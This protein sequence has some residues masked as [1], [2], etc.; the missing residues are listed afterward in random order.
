MD[1]LVYKFNKFKIPLF[2]AVI[3][4]GE[5]LFV[6]NQISKAAEQETSSHYEHEN[7]LAT[8]NVKT[9]ATNQTVI[10]QTSSSGGIGQS[11]PI[12]SDVKV[13][14]GKNMCRT[15]NDHPHK[16]KKKIPVHIDGECC[17]D[18]DEIPNSNCYYPQPRYAKMIQ[19]YLN[20]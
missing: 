20:R 19:K 18:P 8:E 11:G 3:F 17:L 13:V 9:T 14:N 6:P 5:F 4:L 10:R 12:L 16:S 7:F 15:N 1:S 2:F